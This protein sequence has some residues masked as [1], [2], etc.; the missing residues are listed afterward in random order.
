MT[1]ILLKRLQRDPNFQKKEQP[2]PAALDTSALNNAI[3]ELI[4]QA[5]QA[6]AEEAIKKQ[7]VQAPAPARSAVPEHLQPFTD[8]PPSSEFPPPT[9]TTKAPRDL[10]ISTQRDELKRLK[11]ITIG[12][13][14]RFEVQRDGEGRVVRMVQLD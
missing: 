1:S 5:A 14:V 3:G 2:P 9:A 12:N 7:P 8:K 11:Y 6:G 13:D 10:T 4:K